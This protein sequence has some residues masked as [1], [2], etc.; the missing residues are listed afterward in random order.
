M[1]ACAFAEQVARQDGLLCKE[2]SPVGAPVAYDFFNR[3]RPY[4]RH[5]DQSVVLLMVA[6]VAVPAH[7]RFR[8]IPRGRSA[9]AHRYAGA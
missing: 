4:I 3:H 1:E 2:I 5:R 8:R 9:A 7:G 6:P